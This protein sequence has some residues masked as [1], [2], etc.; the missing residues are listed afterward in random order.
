MKKGSLLPVAGIFMLLVTTVIL[1]FVT[2]LDFSKEISVMRNNEVAFSY[3]HNAHLIKK[4]FEGSSYYI[5]RYSEKE[6]AE[7]GC[8][9]G[10]WTAT[11]PTQQD[12]A[13]R[14]DL[15]LRGRLQS[16]NIYE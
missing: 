12:C 5:L 3:L 15:I 16:N 7:T 1:A 8:G 13:N 6:A 14:L 4:S 10:V 11:S 2:S 9:Q